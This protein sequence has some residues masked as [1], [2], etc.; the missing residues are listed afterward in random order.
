MG[1]KKQLDKVAREAIEDYMTLIAQ[2]DG[3]ANP[4][5]QAMIEP[6]RLMSHALDL[7]AR[8]EK[9]MGRDE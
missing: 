1:K 8:V 9:I 5:M 3:L 7:F 4:M 6:K 2:V